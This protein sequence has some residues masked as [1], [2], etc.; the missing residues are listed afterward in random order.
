[1]ENKKIVP[2]ELYDEKYFL[3][4]DGCEGVEAFLK[5]KGEVLTSRLKEVLDEI[6]TAEGKNVLEL[7]SGRGEIALHLEKTAAKMIC[8]DYSVSA[9]KIATEILKKATVVCA[10]AT[11]YLPSYTEDLFD[12]VIM[13]D[14][15][16]HLYDY[17]L[18]IVFKEVTRLTHKDSLVYVDTPIINK[19]MK[20]GEMHVNIKKSF[21]DVSK[22]LP[23]FTLEKR[24]L[25]DRRGSNYLMIFKKK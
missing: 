5:S 9:C 16:E 2:P 8:V 11:I 20:H 3:G 13:N 12:I 1:M 7:G 4:H 19:K 24:K 15:I 10:D 6:K 23:E 25:T 14:F 18:D 22:F 21:E 17:Q